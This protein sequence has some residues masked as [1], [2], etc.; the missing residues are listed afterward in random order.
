MNPY[1][2]TY[3]GRHFNFTDPREIDIVDIA[4]ALA[5]LCR[6]TGH[7]RTFCSVAQHSVA[8]SRLVPREHALAGLMHDASEAYLGDVSMPLKPLLPGYRE[9]EARVHQAIFEHFGIDPVLPPEVKRADMKMLATERLR[10]M[11]DDPTPWPC[12]EGIEPLSGDGEFWG[13]QRAEVEFLSRF[14]VL[15]R[16]R[17]ERALTP[18]DKMPY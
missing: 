1:I 6:F 3:T 9:I 4:H 15:L 10:L 13:P 8:V 17:D 16:Q 11:P 5:N 14:S 2:L 7:T 12:L 18:S